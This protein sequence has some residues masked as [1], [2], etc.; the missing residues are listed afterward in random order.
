MAWRRF[1]LSEVRRWSN[2][3]RP[4]PS[5]MCNPFLLV[6]SLFHTII[7]KCAASIKQLLFQNLMKNFKAYIVGI[8]FWMQESNKI[9]RC[10]LYYLEISENF[11]RLWKIM[12]IKF[13]HAAEKLQPR[14]GKYNDIYYFRCSTFKN[15]T[16][17]RNIYLVT[18]KHLKKWV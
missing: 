9:S 16:K 14:N 3:A 5:F 2:E 4:L 11:N 7:C 12:V 17:S 18:I 15:G 6:K 10:Y 1:L 13:Q 8:C